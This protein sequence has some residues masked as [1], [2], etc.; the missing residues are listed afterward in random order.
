MD[1]QATR[2]LGPGDNA[3]VNCITACTSPNS[4][5]SD[6]PCLYLHGTPGMP[7][8]ARNSP[9]QATID[10]ALCCLHLLSASALPQICSALCLSNRQIADIASAYVPQ[11]SAWCCHCQTMRPATASE[12]HTRIYQQ[13]ACEGSNAAECGSAAAGALLLWRLRPQ[14]GQ[15]CASGT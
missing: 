14:R 11:V 3:R 5:N 15:P 10:R 1:S 4:S 13:H 6:S 7:P 12:H 9:Q 8:A 2:N